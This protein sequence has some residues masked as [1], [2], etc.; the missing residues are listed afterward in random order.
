ME[1]LGTKSS[2]IIAK[3]IA[4]ALA[5]AALAFL[6]ALPQESAIAASAQQENSALAA[7]TDAS[8]DASADASTLKAQAAALS[9]KQQKAFQKASADFALELFSRSVAAK[10]KNANVTIAPMSVLTACAMA[11]NGAAGKTGKQ[12]RSVLADGASTTALNKRLQWYGAKLV[13][14]AKAHI[15]NANA[16]WYHSGGTLTVKQS[17]LDVNKTYLNA[18]V[19]AAD[20]ADQRTANDINAWVSDKTNGMIKQIVDNVSP[21]MRFVLANAVYFD[22]EWKRPYDDGDVRTRTFTTASGKKRKVRMMYSTENRYIEA[23]GVKGFIRPYAKGYSYVALLPD[24]GTSVKEFLSTLDGKAFRKLVSGA[25][26]A[27]VRAG[28]PKYSI[29]YSNER[30]NGQLMAMGVKLAFDRDKANFSNMGKDTTGNLYIDQVIH[31]TKVEVDERGTKAAAVTAVMMKA[32]MATPV[33]TKTVVLNRPFVYA[34][35][36]NTTKLPVFIGAVNNIG[37]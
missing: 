22:A 25:K 32:A 36:D 19:R 23:K 8:G 21:D 5:L 4:L 17:F 2:A 26:R 12:L 27:T 3:A 9:K 11:N 33:K 24:K 16:I 35:I 20:F 34:I 1:H 28:I 7:A 37:S 30:M 10:G 6:A 14:T 15:S 29:S 13:D 18:D 31:K